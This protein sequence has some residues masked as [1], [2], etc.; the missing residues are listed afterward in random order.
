[1]AVSRHLKQVRFSHLNSGKGLWFVGWNYAWV[2][3]YVNMT[4]SA[5]AAMDGFRFL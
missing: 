4:S 2:F 5:R 3:S 1:M